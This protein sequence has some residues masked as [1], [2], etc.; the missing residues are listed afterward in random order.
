MRTTKSDLTAIDGY[1]VYEVLLEIIH[2]QESDTE[3][4]K[5]VYKLVKKIE[6]VLY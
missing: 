3:K 6:K 2:T 4:M 1:M 5:E